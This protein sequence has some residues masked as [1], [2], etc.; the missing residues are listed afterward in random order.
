M[1]RVE[2][3]AR[4]HPGKVREN[5]EDNFYMCGVYMRADECNAGGLYKGTYEDSASYTRF[6]TE[7]AGWTKEKWR[8]R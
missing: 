3:A 4:S 7:W 8:R 1:A 2:A 5:N 6:A